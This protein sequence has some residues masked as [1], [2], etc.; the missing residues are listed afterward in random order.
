MC[1]H[2]CPFNFGSSNNVIKSRP[3]KLNEED[4]LRLNRLRSTAKFT[5]TNEMLGGHG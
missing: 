2:M 5:S 3:E 1:V 4:E